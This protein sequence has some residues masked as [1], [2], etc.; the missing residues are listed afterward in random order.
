MIWNQRRLDLV[1]RF[2]HEDYVQ[3]DQRA[4][5]VVRGRD[6]YV[7]SVEALRGLFCDPRMPSRTR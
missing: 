7:D 3:V 6:G 5:V 1:A 2:V 4:E